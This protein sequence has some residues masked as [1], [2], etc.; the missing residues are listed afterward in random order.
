MFYKVRVSI[1]VLK[2]TFNNI[3]G[4]SLRSVILVEETRLPWENKWPT[5][6]HR[7]TLSHNV[8]PSTLRERNSNSQLWWRLALMALHR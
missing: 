8:V 2:D 7:Q 3:S 4:R 5:A 1:F 6:S